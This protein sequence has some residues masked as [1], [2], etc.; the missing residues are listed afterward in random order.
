MPATPTYTLLNQITLAT[1]TATV[2]FSSIPQNYGDFVIVA[3]ATSDANSGLY[4]RFNGDTGSN[5]FTVGAYGNGSSA[6][7]FS[8]NLTFTNANFIS[9]GRGLNTMQ[10]MDYA[11]IDK[12]K[13]MLG[14]A[15]YAGNQA[16]MAAARWASTSA[17]TSASLFMDSGRTF[18]I[19]STF[20]LYGLV[21]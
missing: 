1:S 3:D 4:L 19:G 9:S 15:S 13:T 10:V 20:Y 7:S 18:Q 8:Q 2:T 17:I 11:A 5:Y 16:Q 6:I 21:A 14:R 12:H